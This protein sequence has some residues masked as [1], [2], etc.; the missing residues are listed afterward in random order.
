MIKEKIELK[1]IQIVGHLGIRYDDRNYSV[2][3]RR[4][5]SCCIDLFV[6]NA[7]SMQTRASVDTAGKFS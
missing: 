4:S 5:D 2:N 6:C 3:S 1:P 7:K